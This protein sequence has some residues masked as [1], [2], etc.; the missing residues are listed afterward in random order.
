MA[1]TNLITITD[2]RTY[3]QVDSKFDAT[4]F[5]AFCQDIQRGNLRS[6]LGDALYKGLM[7]SDRTS[8]IYLDLI[9]GKD[10]TYGGESIHFYGIKPMLCYWW[11]ALATREGDLFLSNVG[12]FGYSNNPQQNFESAKEKE[13]IAT[14]Y[15]QMAQGYANDSIKFLDA[16]SSD[17]PLWQSNSS[18]IEKSNILSFKI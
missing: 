12:A 18:E 8:G 7:D 17:Y 1:E 5:A 2:V 4:R 3:R 15:V 11:L 13:R 9:A 14:N 16:N 10:Y 6:L